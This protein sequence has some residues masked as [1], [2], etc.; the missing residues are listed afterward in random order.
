MSKYSL[1]IENGEVIVTPPAPQYFSVAKSVA[2]EF[3]TFGSVEWEEI[4]L[5][6]LEQLDHHSEVIKEA[7]TRHQECHLNLCECTLEE[8]EAKD[9]YVQVSAYVQG[10]ADATQA[11][12]KSLENHLNPKEQ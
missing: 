10:Y 12:I 5:S 4:F 7:S 11:F 6:I 3:A 8:E 9:P 1:S 2:D